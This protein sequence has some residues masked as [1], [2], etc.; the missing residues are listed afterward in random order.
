MALGG[1]CLRFSYG[2][3]AMGQPIA[4]ELTVAYEKG[5]RSFRMS[6]SDW[7]LDPIATSGSDS[8]ERFSPPAPPKSN[9]YSVAGCTWRCGLAQ[10][11]VVSKRW[12]PPMRVVLDTNVLV[13]ALLK[14]ES[15]P[16]R[17]CAAIWA[18][19]HVG[20]LYDE[21]ILDEYRT[22]LARPKFK[23]LDPART[24]E[25]IATIIARGRAI[26]D[27]A[28]WAGPLPDEGDRIFVELALAGRADAIV[29]GNIK[30]YPLDLGFDVLPAATLLAQL[31]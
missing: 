12:L 30:H 29:T 7:G 1:R 31:G 28:P 18:A 24:A 21:R 16:A 5:D 3:H 2:S 9:V 14:P 22:V 4:G 6:W 27:V 10:V 23:A 13:S 8:T 26:A 19:R 15:V 11:F 25:L 17:A 20:L